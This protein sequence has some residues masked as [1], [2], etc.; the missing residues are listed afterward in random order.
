MSQ[1]VR[2]HPVDRAKFRKCVY[3]EGSLTTTLGMKVVLK[4]KCAN[5]HGST[6]IHSSCAS[7]KQ[8]KDTQHSLLKPA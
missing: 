7:S 2:L 4:M 6:F 8:M 5:V 3:E 1:S